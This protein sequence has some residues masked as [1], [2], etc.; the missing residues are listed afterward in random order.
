MGKGWGVK[1]KKLDVKNLI[2]FINSFLS[3][4]RF[5][6]SPSAMMLPC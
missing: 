3:T 4:V 2:G 5:E 1:G 6:R